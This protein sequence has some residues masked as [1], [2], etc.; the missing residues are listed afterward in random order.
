MSA[1]YGCLELVVLYGCGVFYLCKCIQKGKTFLF[2]EHSIEKNFL[3]G[4]VYTADI[5]YHISLA[6]TIKIVIIFI[7]HESN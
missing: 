5:C 4:D 6:E 3:P 7:H 2:V 1:K